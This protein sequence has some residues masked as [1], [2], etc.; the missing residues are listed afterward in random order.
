MRKVLIIY[1]NFIIL[2]KR[3]GDREG[4]REIYRERKRMRENE[5]EREYL[6]IK[7]YF[8]FE[9]NYL[10]FRL[11]RFK[12]III[13]YLNLDLNSFIKILKIFGLIIF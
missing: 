11:G 9:I 10:I 13:F 5:G 6:Y 2:S 3:K 12:M 7:F 4:M 1:E 8:F